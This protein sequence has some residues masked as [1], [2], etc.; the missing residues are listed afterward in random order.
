MSTDALGIY[1]RF[2][3]YLLN[4]EFGRLGEVVDMD[5]YTENCV[6]LT[7]WTTGL[8]AALGNYQANVAAAFS[9]MA[10]SEEDVLEAGD[11]VVIRSVITAAHTGEFLGIGPT[12]RTVSY[13]A[14][15]MYRGPAGRPR[16]GARVARRRHRLHDQAGSAVARPPRRRLGRR[17]ARPPGA[18]E[19]DPDPGLVRARRAGADRPRPQS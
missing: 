10:M 16:G 9:D 2:Q 3:S 17:R 1:R 8:M 19:L 12:G 4:G 11:A 6:G 13:D 7:G 5:G 14:V 15:D 18:H